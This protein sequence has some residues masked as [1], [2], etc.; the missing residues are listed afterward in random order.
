M[1]IAFVAAECTPL[2]KVGGLADVVGALSKA[3]VAAGHDVRIFLP[4]YAALPATARPTPTP[5]ATRI[6]TVDGP[7]VARIRETV[8]PQST[9]PIYL[10]GWPDEFGGAVYPLEQDAET[11]HSVIRRFVRFSIATDALIR[12][13]SWRPDIIHCHD[14]HTALIPALMKTTDDPAT[15]LTIHNLDIQGVWN[16][17]DVVPLLPSQ[18]S[19]RWGLRDGRGDLNLLQLGITY[20]NQVTTVSPTYATE[21]VTPENGERLD[22]ELRRA[23]VV[24]ILNGIDTESYDPERDHSLASTYSSTTFVD[25]K[26]DNKLALQRE[27]GL[28]ENPA[29]PVFAMVGRLVAQKGVNLLLPIIERLQATGGQVAVLGTGFVEIEKQLREAQRWS[30][31][32]CHFGFDSGLGRRLYAGSDFF[33]MPSIFEPC[34]LGQLIALRYGSLPIIRNTGGLHDTVTDIDAFPETGNGFVFNEATSAALWSTI[35]RALRAYYQPKIM[36]RAVERSM[37][38][39]HS[40]Y[41]SATEYVRLYERISQAAPH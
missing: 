4:D 22:H 23:G 41:T 19:G 25:G 39:D 16:P 3:L 20:A 26:L 27:L 36:R 15:V 18:E 31:V 9:V 21:I 32:R 1:R 30:G 11:L 7:V 24:G 37:R 35:E 40:W 12:A 2:I 10:V 34:G 38:I 8:L 6:D 5:W 13:G 29:A 17:N 14:W 33:L 28:P